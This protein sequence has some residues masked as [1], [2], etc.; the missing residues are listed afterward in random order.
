VS[1][2]VLSL[3]NRITLAPVIHGSADFALAVR[4]LMLEQRFDCVA[5][6]LPESFR[7]DV[8]QAMESLPAPTVVLQR[9]SP[10]FATE[11]EAVERDD[12]DDLDA[13]CSYVPIDPC[14]PVIMALRI[15][16]GERIATQFIDLET[17]RF[18]PHAGILPDP[19]ALKQVA[20]E[21][22]AAAVLPAIPRP[23]AGQR[24]DRIRHMARR[25]ADLEQ[26]YESILFVCSLFDWPWIRE[27]YQERGRS[28]TN[29]STDVASTEIYAVDPRTLIFLLGELPYITGL[30][31]R[32]RSELEDDENLSID[33]VK[34]LLVEAR[35]RYRRDLKR[36]ARQ[37]T[38]YLLSQ[39]LKYLRNLTLIERRLTPDLYSLVIAAK[40]VAGDQYAL[41]VA[42]TARDYPI[43][44]AAPFL[45]LRMGIER[46]RLP[47]GET[48][49]MVSRLPGSPVIWR[50]CELQR[51]PVKSELEKWRMQWNPF[52]QCSWP[53]EDELIENFRAHVF[54]RAKSIV[55]AD[56]ARTEKFTTSVQDGVD[57]RETLRHWH[58][59]GIYVKVLP[60][61]RGKL[62]CVVMLF[63]A[64]ADPRDYPWRTT[65]FA[66]HENE[67]TLAFFA[68]DFRQELVGPGIGVATY[69]GALFLFP[70][71]LVPDI[72]TDRR[73][74]FTT[75]LE[76]R[77]LG[78]ACLHSR[79]PQIA[80]LSA[81]PLG[82]GWRRLARRF[83][84][85]FVH[86]PL[87]HFGESTIQQL[88]MA[89]VL[90]GKQVRSYAAHFI[91]KA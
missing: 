9:A 32:A 50:K 73:L 3:G 14:Q 44:C 39:C 48:V 11:W 25:L 37:I 4:Q 43:A 85:K 84:R 35:D 77:L 54:D 7:P 47:D 21:R 75:T 66:E 87:G 55:G 81:Q 78:A 40:Q 51:R 57:F 63:D 58:E 82:A 68:T 5:V 26:R 12:E 89:H 17:D 88:R 36:R 71:I 91:R 67:S 72:W 10:V 53:P 16:A 13:E 56:L 8:Q 2:D 61:N 15:A 31:E 42:E 64:P 83:R 76:E 86:V 1:R 28:D 19:Y 90:N 74:D 22:F 30:Y 41:H 70:P 49:R 45:P 69:G 46:A 20:W 62:D 33:G 27:A 80:V 79:C 29:E 65:W 59:G 52:S 34:E 18:Q 24:L 6:P 38:P 23:S 60:P